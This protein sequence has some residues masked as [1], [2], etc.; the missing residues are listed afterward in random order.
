MRPC[1]VDVVAHTAAERRGDRL[2]AEEEVDL[3]RL[4]AE[5]L[6]TRARAEIRAATREVCSGHRTASAG[7]WLQGAVLRIDRAILWDRDAAQRTAATA[8]R[9]EMRTPTLPMTKMDVK[10]DPAAAADDRALIEHGAS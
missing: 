2:L 9:F 3:V 7:A 10:S 5:D 4:L 1:A 6:R 8:S